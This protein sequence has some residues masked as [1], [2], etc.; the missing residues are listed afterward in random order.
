LDYY[1]IPRFSWFGDIKITMTTMA[2]QM[3]QPKNCV[4]VGL[5]KTGFSC[6][7][8]LSQHHVNVAVMDT[9]KAPPALIE[10]QQAY[11][12]VLVK[13]G[14]LDA[15]WLQQADM[16]VLSPG[17]DPRHPAI[18][19]AYDVGVDVVGDIE[20]F[21]R[22]VTAPVV[23]IT[24]SN[25]KST[26][27]TLLAEMA[28]LAGK[29][30][31][32]GGNLGTPALDLI[33]EPE[34]DFYILELSSFQLETVSTLNAFASVV[35]NVSPDHLDRYDSL[36]DYK[37]AKA[38]IYNGDGVMIINQDD[39][40]VASLSRSERN[41]IGFSLEASENLDFGVITH[42][43]EQWL[44][45]G[46]RPLLAVN[47]MKLTGTHNVANA[48]AALALGSAMALPM[49]VM[50]EAIKSFT[51][52][53]HRCQF[54]A[55]AADAIWF[56]DSKATNVGACIAAINGLVNNRDIVLIAGGEGKDQ[57]F[58]ALSPVLQQSVKAVVLF[59]KDAAKIAE[60][61]PQV[62]ASVIVDDMAAAVYQAAKMV[63][64]GD[65]V[66]LSPACA[67][68]DMFSGYE[69]RGDAFVHCVQELSQ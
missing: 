68:F 33:T 45:E 25:G 36:N 24:G 65:K 22:Y 10:L 5:G 1:S 69:E 11:P 38:K 8:Y 55:A 43:C 35:L 34:P 12:E 39:P 58:S 14:E 3:N 49:T 47:E 4:I 31:Q 42:Q 32:A 19:A 63:S 64:I 28:E 40:V 27:T 13:T 7:K 9:R 15:Q 21:A 17:V 48:L 56:N 23:A 59:G 57:D 6:A 52:L 26:V 30:V 46:D 54:V 66:L 61:V 51:G 18:Q 41:T 37:N 60:I 44:A 67:S 20:L 2:E 50:L 16:I 53:P 29:T 62:V